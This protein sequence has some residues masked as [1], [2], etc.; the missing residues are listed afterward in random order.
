MA[1][2][3]ANVTAAKPVV[4]GAVYR[5]PLGSTLPTDAKTALDAAFKAMGYVSTDGLANGNAFNSAAIYAWGG[6]AVLMTENEKADTFVFTLLEMLNQEVQKAVYGTTN[7]TVASGLTTI[8]K[9]ADEQEEAAWVFEMKLRG[10][11]L[12]RIVVP[13][14]KITA[15]GDIVYQ[16]ANVAGYP[17]TLSAMP[18]SNG[19]FHREY[20][21]MPSTP[22]TP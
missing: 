1:Q 2:T 21:E 15:L 4:A 5:A 6:D 12:K 3:V 17:I 8:H 13:D 14:A 16:D 7:V 11:K 18:D 20:I 9:K 10:G 19:D 22:S